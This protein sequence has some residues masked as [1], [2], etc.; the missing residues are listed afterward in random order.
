MS[1]QVD[2]RLR[3]GAFALE[4]AFAAGAGLTT[5]FGRSGSGKTTLIDLIAGLTRPDRG[6]IVVGG[7]VLVD[8]AGGTFLP[9]HRRRIGVVFQDAR[10]FPHL[11][12]RGNL[13]YGRARARQGRDPAT[14]DRVTFDSVTDML[15]IHHLLDR[16][17]AGL[18]GG[19]RQR[20]AIG[21]ALLAGP[22]L[23]L[24]DEPLA[25]LDEARKAE[26]LPY[27][28]RLRDE[29][30][31]PIVYVSHAV[32][33][34]A[35]LATT[36]VVLEAG[37]VAA[38]GPA[39]AILRRADLVPVHEAEAG[40]LLDM[41]VEGTD[42]ETGLT[43]LTGPAGRLLV[44]G[45]SLQPGTR[46][47]VRIPARDVLVATEPPRGLSARN[48]LAGRVSRLIPSGS[49]MAVEIDC[50]GACIVARLTTAAV[51]ELGLAIGRPVYAIVKSAAFDPAGIGL[52]R[53]PV[54]I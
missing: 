50:G 7:T 5:L 43:D 14:L 19:E 18:S 10:L 42:A 15:G 1:I 13:G 3:R 29:T 44:P 38:A 16:R 28:E 26:I 39:E 4:A 25:A 20:V 24:M 49:E 33:E 2:V 35:R 51:R 36:V 53:S 21:R 52:L 9:P 41:R 37:R 17:P 6:R 48:I 11:S 31:V 54:T 32:S 8:T 30:G 40:A 12:V 22:R 23:L 47:R 34:V 45:L 27:I 46:L